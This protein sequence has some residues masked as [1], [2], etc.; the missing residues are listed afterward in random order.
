MYSGR[1]IRET[2]PVRGEY[3]GLSDNGCQRRVQPEEASAM[4]SKDMNMVMAGVKDIPRLGGSTSGMIDCR[5]CDQSIYVVSFF[6]FLLFQTDLET[7][8]KIST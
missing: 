4:T 8:R 3:I 7:L 1:C 2:L 5:V 6:F